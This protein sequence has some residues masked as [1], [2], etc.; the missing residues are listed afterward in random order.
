MK[1]SQL[2]YLII[3]FIFFSPGWNNE[4]QA[5]GGN[6]ISFDGTD[7][8]V[9]LPNDAVNSFSGWTEITIEYWF[10]GTLLQSPVRFQGTGGDY[11]VAGWSS[12]SVHIISTDGGTGNGISVGAIND[13]TWH[14]YAMV[15]KRNTVNGFK[16][17]RDGAL[18]AQRTSLDV[19][20][21]PN[22]GG[23][24]L[25][26]YAWGSEY[27]NGCLD[28]VRVWK[29]A[30]TQAEIQVFMNNAVPGNTTGL[31]VYYQ[32]N[33]GIAG[34]NNAGLTTLS[35]ITPNNKNGTL[36]NFALNGTFSNWV[37]GSA[38]YAVPI[39]IWAI[40]GSFILIGFFAFLAFKK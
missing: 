15:W 13:N 35:D 6:S 31:V 39:S 4:V 12:P 5:Q 27:L 38:I 9:S 34:G 8:Y 29:V 11:I 40:I 3:C 16:S 30:R 33:Q 20:L 10:K 25:G 23:N 2:F 32:F 37:G 18:I 17:Y 22:N 28:E 1:R 24:T 26:K 7:D 19:P 14:H 21:P 36:N